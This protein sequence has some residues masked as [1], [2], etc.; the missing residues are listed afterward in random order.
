M[1]FIQIKK[2]LRSAISGIENVFAST[3]YE[4]EEGRSINLKIFVMNDKIEAF[5]NDQ[6]SPLWNWFSDPFQS[7]FLVGKHSLTM[8]IV[9]GGRDRKRKGCA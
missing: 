6:I 1:W 8:T 4:F 3:T 5:L 2:Y 9:C 7:I